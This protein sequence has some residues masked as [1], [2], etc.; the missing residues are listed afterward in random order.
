MPEYEKQSHQDISDKIKSDTRRSSMSTT[1]AMPGTARPF[2][3]PLTPPDAPPVT[4]RTHLSERHLTQPL[5]GS[6]AVNTIINRQ[7]LSV[8]GFPLTRLPAP[9][10][11]S[12]PKKQHDGKA[13]MGVLE[14]LAKQVLWETAQIL[15]GEVLTT[16]YQK[17][18]RALR[19]LYYEITQISASNSAFRD[20]LSHI[21]EA[22]KDHAQGAGWV[23]DYLEAIAGWAETLSDEWKTAELLFENVKNEGAWLGKLSHLAQ[24]AERVLSLPAIIRQLGSENTGR[25]QQVVRPLKMFLV[26]LHALRA[27][28]EGLR[29]QDYLTLVLAQHDILP[30]RLTRLLSLGQSLSTLHGVNP[31]PKAAP[32]P[33]QLAWIAETL[34]DPQVIEDARPLLGDTAADNLQQ[35]LAL[36]RTVQAFPADA[37][38]YQQAL[39]LPEMLSQVPGLGDTSA[40]GFLQRM[41][42]AL[43]DENE[44]RELFD[45]V[46]KLTNP[47]AAR[48]E[49][50]KQIGLHAGAK[51]LYQHGPALVYQTLQPWL[52]SWLSNPVSFLR[53]FVHSVK[54]EDNWVRVS[55]RLL[56]TA[57]QEGP[58]Y[59]INATTGN[60]VALQTLQLATDIG[61]HHSFRD[62]LI[63]I[64]RQN[65]NENSE[66]KSLYWLYTSG[67]LCWQTQRA[68][69]SGSVAER[70]AALRDVVREIQGTQITAIFPQL[71]KLADLIP[72]LPALHEA[73]KH[74]RQAEGEHSWLGWGDMVIDALT[75]SSSP[76]LTRLKDSLSRQMSQWLAQAIHS[77][78]SG[79]RPAVP[80]GAGTP[81]NGVQSLLHPPVTLRVGRKLM[82]AEDEEEPAGSWLLPAAEAAPVNERRADTVPLPGERRLDSGTMEPIQTKTADERINSE[83]NADLA[84]VF[85]GDDIIEDDEASTDWRGIARSTAWTGMTLGTL[86]TLGV[87]LK[88]LYTQRRDNAETEDNQIELLQRS[89]D[90]NPYQSTLLLKNTDTQQQVK[91]GDASG[92]VTLPLATAA[93]GIGVPAMVL[94]GL[95]LTEETPYNPPLTL[96]ETD[97]VLDELEDEDNGMISLM[98]G[99]RSAQHATPQ[100]RHRHSQHEFVNKI[101][102]HVRPQRQAALSTRLTPIVAEICQVYK[103]KHNR[104]APTYAR[105]LLALDRWLINAKIKYTFETKRIHDEVLML[106]ELQDAVR[107]HLQLQRKHQRA[108]DRYLTAATVDSRA[109]E[110]A[111]LNRVQGERYEVKLTDRVDVI[112]K[113][114]EKKVISILD[115]LR[116]ENND[117]AF[118]YYSY[119]FSQQASMVL[120]EKYRLRNAGVIAQPATAEPETEAD[121]KKLAESESDFMTVIAFREGGVL[122]DEYKKKHPG[123]D[124]LNE[125]GLVDELEARL[126]VEFAKLSQKNHGSVTT[127]LDTLLNEQN[128]KIGELRKDRSPTHPDVKIHLHLRTW[129]QLQKDWF[130]LMVGVIDKVNAYAKTSPVKIKRGDDYSARQQALQLALCAVRAE[131]KGYRQQFEDAMQELNAGKT[132]LKLQTEAIYYYLQKHA[133]AGLSETKENDLAGMTADLF[134]SRD[135]GK[136]FPTTGV[137][138]QFYNASQSGKT[139]TTFADLMKIQPWTLSRKVYNE[140]IN[141]YIE[142]PASTEASELGTL[143]A[144]MARIYPPD[145]EQAPRDIYKARIAIPYIELHKNPFGEAIARQDDW[146]TAPGELYFIKTYSDDY[147]LISTIAHIPMVIRL[148]SWQYSDY[149]AIMKT[150]YEDLTDH[151][152]AQLHKLLEMHGN[153]LNYLDKPDSKQAGSRT[154]LV[155][156]SADSIDKTK[157][158]KK[159]LNQAFLAMQEAI[160]EGLKTGWTPYQPTRFEEDTSLLE[161][162][163]EAGRQTYRFIRYTIPGYVEDMSVFVRVIKAYLN[164]SRYSLGEEDKAEMIVEAIFSLASIGVKLSLVTAKGIRAVINAGRMAKRMGLSAAAIR[165]SMLHSAR[166]VGGKLARTGGG[167]LF[168][169]ATDVMVPFKGN[170]KLLSSI[171][172]LKRGLPPVIDVNRPAQVPDISGYENV[173]SVPFNVPLNDKAITTFNKLN[174]RFSNKK[175]LSA[176]DVKFFA[177]ENEKL[178]A[179]LLGYS[180]VSTLKAAAI[181]DVM[182]QW[183]MR[184]DLQ[185]A[186]NLSIDAKRINEFKMDFNRFQEKL[187]RYSSSDYLAFTKKFHDAFDNRAKTFLKHYQGDNVEYYKMPGGV[188]NI[189]QMKGSSLFIDATKDAL[190][191]ISGTPDGKTILQALSKRNSP[192]KINP[193]TLVAVSYEASGKFYGKNY[194]AGESITFDPQNRN[195]GAPGLVANEQWRHR[196]PSV[197]LF[198]EL[199]H[200][201]YGINKKTYVPRTVPQGGNG[202]PLKISG[203]HTIEDEAMI[204]GAN[205]IDPAG[206][207]FPFSDV[208]Y[209]PEEKGTIFSEN[210]FRQQLAY[211][212]GQEKYHFRPYYGEK[213]TWYKQAETFL[214]VPE[215]QKRLV[216]LNRNVDLNQVVPKDADEINLTKEFNLMGSDPKAKKWN[217]KEITKEWKSINKKMNDQLN[218]VIKQL[219]SQEPEIRQGMN[220]V[221]ECFFG[222]SD[223]QIYTELKEGYTKIARDSKAFNWDENFQVSLHTRSDNTAIAT[224]VNNYK[225]FAAGKGNDEIVMTSYENSFSGVY[226]RFQ[227]SKKAFSSILFHEFTHGAMDTLDMQYRGM[228]PF[229]LSNGEEINVP[230]GQQSVAG[231]LTIR[232]TLPEGHN[233]WVN[234]NNQKDIAYHKNQRNKEFVAEKI[235]T[236]KSQIEDFNKL[237][238]MEKVNRKGEKA[239]LDEELDI[240]TKVQE[241]NQHRSEEYTTGFDNADSH[242]V[243]FRLLY[244]LSKDKRKFQDTLQTIK[245]AL[246]PEGNVKRD[247]PVFINQR[248]K[249]ATS[250]IKGNKV[251]E[252]IYLLTFDENNNIR[253]IWIKKKDL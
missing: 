94:L 80:A 37:G 158:V 172:S 231:L 218:I 152:Y 38:L 143:Y 169:E 10:V 137:V 35:T 146:K 14:Q 225:L 49:T 83:G 4:P 117:V 32:A 86:V 250:E 115:M 106:A 238:R 47:D 108:I 183:V 157:P 84:D 239:K 54:A 217:A 207:E 82:S 101:L 132:E 103:N 61:R 233:G 226:S 187:S 236:L 77:G 181:E 213:P 180:D 75:N 71:E 55:E 125:A 78:L 30:A 175:E 166:K 219:D 135:A 253:D 110:M 8:S 134:L 97:R 163:E 162:L 244:L 9:A 160:S 247:F 171:I 197:G 7:P 100:Q 155:R 85:N 204:T 99:K 195:V 202:K 141:K 59:I 170:I 109:P 164:D 214:P 11:L 215:E 179:G 153:L 21:A 5:S 23:R 168:D 12:S 60:S 177:E 13:I 235:A 45:M 70:E 243:V 221:F 173:E 224:N 178:L 15:L 53:K 242:G 140:T 184:V 58:G 136:T 139:Y 240:Y 126:S 92:H 191:E 176:E 208:N 251:V 230:D 209:L 39:W 111:V 44:S 46:M 252:H 36:A 130:E 102:T 81:N 145:L 27:Q 148:K 220:E 222:R 149:V 64:V 26:Q 245:S 16:D 2:P 210:R 67:M 34:S 69:R 41:R 167:E 40:A 127:L 248:R 144:E 190:T 48:L 199:L 156:E 212:K 104:K 72:L 196:P 24:E 211:Q 56:D 216:D 25:I 1:P 116:N 63:Y 201:Y 3:S 193:P 42:Q 113:N 50:I 200:I 119:H 241:A 227:Y 154:Y 234:H 22:I 232:K 88:S 95:H 142:G 165:R 112:N 128:T 150:K 237:Q 249:R 228:K 74:I 151:N 223:A 17:S 131:K 206:R 122:Y 123:F 28:P 73:G 174:K 229:K 105:L 188:N 192:I 182:G 52:P 98:R 198:H 19:E 89:A 124:P 161:D 147:L 189:A 29:W 87:M 93:L 118:V 120:L 185:L 51:A 203:S 62:S 186:K 138:T 31:F 129:L 96:A 43:G 79:M 18:S 65:Q 57:L 20:R 91:R 66:A 107:A 133:Q 205:Y 121:R 68:M 114:G 33:E 194:S 159:V 246:D 90:G 6:R 76:M